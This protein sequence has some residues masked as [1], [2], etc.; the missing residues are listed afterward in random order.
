[1][2]A[3]QHMLAHEHFTTIQTKSNGCY[4]CRFQEGSIGSVKFNILQQLSNANHVRQKN[5][6]LFNWQTFKLP[7]KKVA[8]AS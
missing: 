6:Q 8:S 7:N 5:K 1:M 4:A 3:Q 2:Y